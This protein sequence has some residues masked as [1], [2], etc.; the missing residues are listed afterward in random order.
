[1]KS[2]FYKSAILLAGTF[3]L[4]SCLK[5][6]DRNPF[7]GLNT[8]SVYE[9][10]ANYIHVLAK[11]YA[12]LATTGNQGPAGKADLQGIDEGFS[13]YIRVLYNLEELPTDEAVCGW[14]DP[15]IPEL[16]QMAWS[17]DNYWIAGM[18]YRI[19][20][21]IPLC[22][23]FVRESE[24]DK[25]SS[26]GFTDAEQTTI[27]GYRAEARFLRALSYYHAL[28]LFGSVPFV[29]E[30]D[31]PGSFFPSQISRTDLF[32]YIEGELKDM[33]NSLPEPRT[34]EYARADKACAWTLLAKLYLN[35]EV[36]TGTARYA[37]CI[38]YCSKVID[39]GYSL[40]PDYTHL[41]L[42]DNNLSP[43]IIFPVAFDGIETQTWGGTTFLVHSP[44]GGKM[45]PADFGIAGGWAGYRSTSA[46]VNQFQDTIDHRY[47]F[48]KDGQSL[49]I[50]NIG[51]FSQGYPI[52]KW[53]N[54]TSTGSFGSDPAKTQADT[55]FPM[56]RLADV[57]LMY[58]EAVVRG[59]GGDMGTALNYVNALRERAYG[60]GSHD[61]GAIDLNTVFNE[62]S[63]ELEW[64][65]QRRTDLI[66]FK[67]FT[68]G[69]YLW[70]WKGNAQGGTSVAD[71][72]NLYPIPFSDLVA[73][74]N[75]VQ[76]PGY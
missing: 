76:N 58:A 21:Q 67:K 44:V 14:N 74:P 32:N 70:P 72:L 68:G 18:Y 5:D 51:T 41:F 50:D 39:A 2:L 1:M 36:Y 64:E 3:M 34:N 47:L 75:L 35:A 38:T 16:H 6:L 8:E 66:R 52:A 9:D 37:D 30:K 61:L 73:N 54:L 48:F 22:N 26:R 13:Q 11:L 43:E 19:F 60:D 27:R 69:D 29:T 12:G 62:R 46:F 55:D 53:K 45:V 33:E 59:G 25:M 40:E 7:Y 15:G 28:D 20:F 10:P 4:S 23:E 49:E 63:K 17:S 24:D 42:A 57:Y 56:F 71:Y 31:E 65:G